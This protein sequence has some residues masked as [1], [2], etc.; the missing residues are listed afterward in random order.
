MSR[1]LTREERKTL[2]GMDL[3]TPLVAVVSSHGCA[4]ITSSCAAVVFAAMAS[5][6]ATTPLSAG[7]LYPDVVDT[8]HATTA[9][10]P[11]F[12]VIF[13]R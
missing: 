5:V 3:P 10:G 11:I 12:Q 13:Y 2:R 9:S 6:L 7:P 4:K 8:T 1:K